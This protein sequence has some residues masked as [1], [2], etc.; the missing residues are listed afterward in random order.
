MGANGRAR[1]PVLRDPLQIGSYTRKKKK[2]TGGGGAG[3][4]AAYKTMQQSTIPSQQFIPTTQYE[5]DIFSGQAVPQPK[6]SVTP[7]LNM[8]P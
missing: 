7:G 1:A 3:S 4:L 5:S 2:A 8:S 6:H